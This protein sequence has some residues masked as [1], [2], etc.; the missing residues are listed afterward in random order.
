MPHWLAYFLGINDPNGAPY[1]F[2][3][4]LASNLPIF[5][6]FGGVGALLHRN[7]CH[8]KGCWRMARRQVDGTTLNVCF[9]HHPDPP[10]TVEDVIDAAADD[11][12]D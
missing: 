7:N 9:H 5:A 11:A 1:L 4:G 6:I 10:P 3:S 8:V 12:T 2:W